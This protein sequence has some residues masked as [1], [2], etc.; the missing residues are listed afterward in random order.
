MGSPNSYVGV[1]AVQSRKRGFIE[2]SSLKGLLRQHHQ[3]PVD[4]IDI[5]PDRSEVQVPCP[6]AYLPEALAAYPVT[7]LCRSGGTDD[8]GDGDVRVAQQS[9]YT[10]DEVP[11]MDQDVVMEEDER[12]GGFRQ[13]QGAL[14][15][16]V[17]G[18]S[19]AVLP[20]TLD[21]RVGVVGRGCEG[22]LRPNDQ[23]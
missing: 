18:G 22:G 11:V 21:G 9:D 15:Q 20:D 6:V 13:G 8:S 14:D 1:I 12:L 3:Q 4:D 19:Q 2:A 23:S 16:R 7:E 5:P 10:S 17:V